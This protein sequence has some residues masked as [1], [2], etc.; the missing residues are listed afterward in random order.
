MAF[1]KPINRIND[2]EA[3]GLKTRQPESEDEDLHRRQ[4]AIIDHF[5]AQTPTTIQAAAPSPRAMIPANVL[6]SA[7]AMQQ[8]WIEQQIRSTGQLAAAWLAA[9]RQSTDEMLRVCKRRLERNLAGQEKLKR[10]LDR[11]DEIDEEIE[12]GRDLA[13]DEEGSSRTGD[14]NGNGNGD[15]GNGVAGIQGASGDGE[16][17]EEAVDL[18]EAGGIDDECS[19]AKL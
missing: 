15:D 10:L 13:D 2:D 17:A 3:N 5:E 16:E 7:Q 18:V 19:C 11:L 9:Y 1:E 12:R 6:R 8:N 4:Q 14:G